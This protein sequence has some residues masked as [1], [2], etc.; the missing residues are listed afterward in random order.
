MVFQ[1]STFSFQGRKYKLLP[2]HACL[3]K[4]PCCFLK[5][6]E[7]VHGWSY[8]QF[9]RL[10]L[11][12]G[13]L[14]PSL[15]DVFLFKGDL[16]VSCVWQTEWKAV[17]LLEDHKIVFKNIL[18]IRIII[19]TTKFQMFISSCSFCRNRGTFGKGDQICTI[20]FSRASHKSLQIGTDLVTGTDFQ[21]NK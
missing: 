5:V 17:K 21:P 2:I 6:M 13:T 7:Y 10:P 18:R 3:V 4:R 9:S 14:G 11:Q 19:P 12:L 20:C 15:E 16:G 1:P 8:L